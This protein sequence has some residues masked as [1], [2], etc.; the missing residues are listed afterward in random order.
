[1]FRPKKHGTLPAT[2]EPF[3]YSPAEPVAYERSKV[4]SEF[5]IARRLLLS[6]IK[7]VGRKLTTGRGNSI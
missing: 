4:N 7:A 6:R 1:M 3:R 5:C 2:E